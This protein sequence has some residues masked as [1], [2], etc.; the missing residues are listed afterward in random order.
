[1]KAI[2]IFLALFVTGCT[3]SGNSGKVEKADNAATRYAEGLHQGV[4][5]AENVADKANQKIAEYNKTVESAE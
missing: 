2:L 1:M 4:N 3:K 5:K